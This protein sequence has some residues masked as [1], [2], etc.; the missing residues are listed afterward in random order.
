VKIAFVVQ[1]YGTE[2]LGGSEY[3]CRLVAERLSARH[4]VDVLTTCARDYLTWANEYPEGADRLRGVTV[5]RFQTT[6]QRDLAAFNK[7]SERVLNERHTPQDEHEWLKQQGP[8]APG[9]V[10]YLERHHQQYDAIIFFTYLYA[11][12]VLGIRIAPAKSILVPTAHDEPALRL[13][14]YRDVFASAAGI[15]WNTDAE[16]RLV[17]TRFP[18]RTLATEIIGCGVE[19]PEGEAMVEGRDPVPSTADGRE[20]LPP[21]IDGPANAFRRRHRMHA[22]FV[23]YGGRIDPGK[24][25]EELLEYFQTYVHEGGDATLM[26]MGVKMMPLPDDPQVRFAGVLSDEERFRALEAA[27]VVVVPS[28]NESLSLLALEAMAV[29][30]PILVNGRSEVLVEH[31]RQ[32][33]AG[34]YYE[35]RWEFTEALKLLMKDTALRARLGRNGKAYVNKNYRWSQIIQKYER[36]LTAVAG[37][38]TRDTSADR[39][40]D[41]PR[42]D[43]PERGD[44]DRDRGRDRFRHRRPDR[45]RG[46]RARG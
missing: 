3:H 7:L 44:R 1:R 16:R 45:G 36:L 2:I 41:R 39:E 9:I 20:P 40:R 23:L 6:R 17:T 42:E 8:W 28:P 11:P 14:L 22:P 18:L 37:T 29:G 10:D 21:H 12:T 46:Q 25:C 15:A 27:A 33:N 38:T 13:G 43:R 32:S 5:R 30:T 34:L 19:L 26:L 31:C 24:G 35:D 4:Q